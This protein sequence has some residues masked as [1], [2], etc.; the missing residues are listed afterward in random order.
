MPRRPLPY[1]DAELSERITA[2][3]IAR[4]Q[5]FD[6][7]V[8]RKKRIDDAIDYFG[9]QHI[10]VDRAG[11]RQFQPARDRSHEDCHTRRSDTPSAS[12]PRPSARRKIARG[13]TRSPNLPWTIS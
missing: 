2:V 6:I 5:L 1:V 10:A 13:S 11:V 9:A 8:D 12:A 7:D 4:A 3:E